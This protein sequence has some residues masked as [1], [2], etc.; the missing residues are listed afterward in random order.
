MYKLENGQTISK[1]CKINKIP[2]D[3]IWCRITFKNM[4]PDQAVEDFLSKRDK[5]HF[6]IYYYKG[7]TLAQYCK[8]H[9][10][11]Y[12]KITDLYRNLNYRN[13]LHRKQCTMEEVVE[14]FEKNTIPRSKK[15]FYH[16]KPL[17]IACEEYGID[18]TQVVNKY[19]KLN[20]KN[21]CTIEEVVDYFRVDDPV[22]SF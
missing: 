13:K 10:L 15:H 5:P 8:K 14:M 3:S 16:G 11:P 21:P 22:E 6:C 17:K 4:T 18:Y 1:Y 12:Q 7:V 20:L 19:H 9:N 2:Y